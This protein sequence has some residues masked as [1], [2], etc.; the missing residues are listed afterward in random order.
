VPIGVEAKRI[1]IFEPSQPPLHS[2][3]PRARTNQSTQFT[4]TFLGD[5]RGFGPEGKPE[6]GVVA[7]HVFH[8]F[9]PDPLHGAYEPAKKRIGQGI[10]KKINFAHSS[11]TSS[12]AQG[13][14]RR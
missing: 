11:L 9:R 14:L 1:A 4:D 12:R 5:V 13:T 8:S 2:N 10:C 6:G 3:A 7:A